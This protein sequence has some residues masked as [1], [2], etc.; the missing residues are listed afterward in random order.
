[1]SN[2]NRRSFLTIT[3]AAVAFA[4]IATFPA[5]AGPPPHGT[6]VIRGTVTDAHGH[7]VAG[8]CVTLWIDHHHS[9]G[10][11]FTDGHGIFTFPNVMPGH[12]TLIATSPHKLHGSIG[13]DVYA[14]HTSTVTI[15]VR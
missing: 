15:V 7:I 2:L 11:V 6:G 1:M 9:S 4:A 3:A 12:Y 5:S 8:A 14:G 10:K 13:V